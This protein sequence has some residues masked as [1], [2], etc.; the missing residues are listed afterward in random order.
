[1]E[2]TRIEV[3]P[4]IA[5]A[6]VDIDVNA[7]VSAKDSVVVLHCINKHTSK[8]YAVRLRKNGSIDNR[9]IEL[10]LSAGTDC[11][12]AVGIDANRVFEAYVEDTTSISIYLITRRRKNER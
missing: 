10:P 12:I 7:Y 9:T 3:T 1:M 4:A 6:W 8:N 2:D 11:W 5:N